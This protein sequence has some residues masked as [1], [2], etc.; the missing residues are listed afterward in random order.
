M[1]NLVNPYIAGNPVTGSEMFFGRQDVFTYIQQ[2]LIGRHRDNVIVLY[3]QRRTGKTSVLYQMRRHLD[4]RYLCIFVDLHGLALE[5]LNGFLWE[6]ANIMARSLRKDYGIELPPLRDR[7]VFMTD[8]RDSFENEFLSQIWS[9]IGDQHVLLMLDEAIRLQEQIQAGKLEKEVFSYLRHLMQHYEHLNF[10]FSLGS[11][12]EEMEKEYAFLFNVGLYKKISFLEQDAAVALITQPVKDHYQLMPNAI[13]RILQITSGHAYYTQLVCHSLFNRWQQNYKP[14]IT[15]EDVEAILSEVIERGLAVLKHI[16]EESTPGEKAVLAGLAVAMGDQNRPIAVSEI[17]SAWQRVGIRLPENECAKALKRLI[18]R[19]VIV[20]SGTYKFAIDLQRIWVQKYERLEWVKEE[21]AADLQRWQAEQDAAVART[22]TSSTWPGTTVPVVAAILGMILII[23]LFGIFYL[24]SQQTVA[25]TAENSSRTSPTG[26][27]ANI[28]ALAIVDNTIW[29]ATDGGLVRWTA[30]GTGSAFDIT[31]YNFPDNEPGSIVA[32]ADGTLWIGAG[33]VGHL[34]P[35]GSGSPQ[36]LAYY[37]KDDGL[38]TGVI[39]ALMVDQDGSIWAG[40]PQQTRSPLSHFTEESG[41]W[42]NDEIP[43]DSAALQDVDVNIASILRS[44]DGALWLGLRN[45][46]ILRWD[47]NEWTHFG[48]AQGVGPGSGDRRIRS[49]LQDRN[50]TIWAARNDQGLLRFDAG[51]GL[52]QRITVIDEDA[53]IRTIAEFANGELW[54]A[55]DGL[56][57]YS[58]DGGQ[59]WTRVGSATDEIGAS[60]FGM[61]QD[62]SGRVW[63][64]AYDGG[65]SVYENGHWKQLQQ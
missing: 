51:Q 52:W 26:A 18:A 62:A 10:L 25:P 6:L 7:A 42:K 1:S 35:K 2:A 46:G 57:A 43:M 45:D 9:A 36:F 30:D 14:S 53:P 61:V 65:M 41:T 56:V 23:T 24:R 5:G 48:E 17:N 4:Q 28:N 27:A 39:R 55:G 13:D 40:G 63:I 32:G 15:V 49:L 58:K 19:D 20:G 34:R 21:I 12:L 60:I 37:S 16:W 3:G 50:G 29:A 31:D 11:G 44:R 54:A 47:G 38:G 8:A 33:G 22:S 64:G 59:S